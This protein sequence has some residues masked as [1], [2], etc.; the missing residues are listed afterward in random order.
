[1]S[2]GGGSVEDH[3]LEPVNVQGRSAQ[4]RIWDTL[5]PTD[6]FER[7][8]LLTNDSRL[9]SRSIIGTFYQLTVT[10][11]RCQ[12]SGFWYR[13]RVVGRRASSRLEYK[14]QRPGPYMAM[15]H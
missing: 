5:S 13:V 4:D 1:M 6:N 12:A 9:N 8:W 10:D 11:A 7:D 3:G 15:C 2:R 14:S